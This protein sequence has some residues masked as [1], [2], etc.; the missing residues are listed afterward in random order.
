MSFTDK[1]EKSYDKTFDICQKK[2]MCVA[3]KCACL[4]LL[5]EI[6]FF[7]YYLVNDLITISK[8]TYFFLYI[9][10]PTIINFSIWFLG[11][12]LYNSKKI[13]RT[14]QLAIPLI[15]I[16]V[17]STTCATIHYTFPVLCGMLVAPIY[18]STIYGNKIIERNITLC[19]FLAQTVMVI[20]IFNDK[21][22]SRPNLL[23]FNIILSYASI[24]LAHYISTTII[25][26]EKRKELVLKQNVEYNSQLEDELMIDG[27]TGLYNY[28]ALFNLTKENLN[29]NSMQLAIL[30]LDNFKLINDT[31]GH[32][33]GNKVLKKLAKL[34][35]EIQSEN[36]KVA[37][38]G[39]EEFAVL[40][41]HEEIEN[42]YQ[43]LEKIRRKISNVKFENI[44]DRKVTFSGGISSF[45]NN[46]SINDFFDS[47][48][49]LLYIAKANGKNQIIS[50]EL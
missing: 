43:I 1:I 24:L 5:V 27:L 37:R 18:I 14:Q 46:M 20:C 19:T 3:F 31:Y 25:L 13:S 21:Y 40:F 38:Y 26:H 48:D 9:I 7:I 34:L 11:K 23:G 16:L 29:N 44:P 50:N 12:I 8:C 10:K 28:K 47:A 45:K 15:I 42:S 32:E 17:I 36:I 4:M 22:S 6:L 2:L 35:Q 39:G 30:D 41:L 49:K 33:T